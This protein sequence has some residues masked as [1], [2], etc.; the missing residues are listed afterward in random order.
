M[1]AGAAEVQPAGAPRICS[2]AV[3]LRPQGC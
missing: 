3:S 1:P 2:A